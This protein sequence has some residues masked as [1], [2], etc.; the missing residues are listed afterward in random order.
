MSLWL[1][2]LRRNLAHRDALFL[3]LRLKD[4]CRRVHGYSLDCFHSLPDCSYRT[5]SCRRCSRWVQN[6]YR[7]AINLK[8][9]HSGERMTG[10][11]FDDSSSS[12]SRLR[13]S[14]SSGMGRLCKETFAVIRLTSGR[15]RKYVS[16]AS[17]DRGSTAPSMR[18]CFPRCAQ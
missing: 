18:T 1:A 17:T 4:T 16:D 10:E 12:S 6:S 5:R 3:Y 11:V 2:I 7:I 15:C 8:P 13:N 14:Y 9:P